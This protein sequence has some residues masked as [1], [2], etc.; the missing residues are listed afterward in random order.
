VI[1]IRG[2]LSDGR[3]EKFAELLSEAATRPTSGLGCETAAESLHSHLEPASHLP[4]AQETMSLAGR[5]HSLP[6]RTPAR[7]NSRTFSGNLRRRL[8]WRGVIVDVS[9]LAMLVFLIFVTVVV[10]VSERVVVMLMGVPKATVLKVAGYSP[11]AATVMMR[12]MVMV[13]AM[14]HGGV[15]VLWLL[16]FAL[17][18]LSCH[19]WASS[20]LVRSASSVESCARNSIA[21]LKYP[22]VVVSYAQVRRI[23]YDHHAA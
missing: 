3:H 13:V 21:F 20:M 9:L 19:L 14:Y 23:P 8:C 15:S 22:S 5:D 2:P 11:D 4:R 6:R 12:D 7:T 17:G 16:A 1:W 18:T 10:A